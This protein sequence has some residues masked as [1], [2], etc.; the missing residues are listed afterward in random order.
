MNSGVPSERSATAAT[1]SSGSAAPRRA[2]TSSRASAAGRG[3]RSSRSPAS[4]HAAAVSSRLGRAVATMSRPR[5]VGACP[6]ASR[7]ASRSP[8]AQWTSSMSQALAPPLS[9][10]RAVIHA[11][12]RAS[13]SAARSFPVPPLAAAGST[14]RATSPRMTV[15]R[16]SDT[17]ASRSAMSSSPVPAKSCATVSYG[18]VACGRT[19]ARRTAAFP[20]EAANSASRRLFPT[21][22]GATITSRAADREPA[23]AA[24]ARSVGRARRSGR[25][26]VHGGR[27]APPRGRGANER[28]SPPRRGSAPPCP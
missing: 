14:R 7:N 9:A 3:A 23:T 18:A 25:A 12:K 13:R 19:R 21:P 24:S 2:W 20:T 6:A 16:A 26:S 11:S 10:S 15:A 17:P 27:P 28:R 1:S 8:P 22:G 5:A 4:H